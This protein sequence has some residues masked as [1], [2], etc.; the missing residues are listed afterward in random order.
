MIVFYGLNECI[1]VMLR[2]INYQN[3]KKILLCTHSGHICVL[4]LGRFGADRQTILRTPKL[5]PTPGPPTPK[6]KF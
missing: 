1:M 3:E 6:H 2:N 5:A 4:L